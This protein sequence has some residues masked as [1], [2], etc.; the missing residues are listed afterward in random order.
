MLS[1]FE[2][3]EEGKS[4][5]LAGLTGRID[6]SSM[7]IDHCLAED[8]AYPGSIAAL[9]TLT[10]DLAVLLEKELLVLL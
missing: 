9:C 4:C 3:S 5:S 10:F 8:K 1:R 7:Q 6:L 2:S